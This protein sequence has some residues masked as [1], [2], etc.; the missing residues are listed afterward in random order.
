IQLKFHILS[1]DN[2]SKPQAITPDRPVNFPQEMLME[3]LPFIGYQLAFWTPDGKR[4]V[5]NGNLDS[6]PNTVSLVIMDADGNHV[7]SFLKD[8]SKS[9]TDASW[10]PDGKRLLYVYWD[11]LKYAGTIAT[12]NTDGSDLQLFAVSTQLI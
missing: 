10:S 3:A 4:I 12:S 7:A 1:L 9:V 5:A 8:A 2:S 6:Q 11:N